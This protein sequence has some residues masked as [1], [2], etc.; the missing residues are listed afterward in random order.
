M[1]A[2]CYNPKYLR[3]RAEELRS[4]AETFSSDAKVKLLK[5]ADDYDELAV[6]AEER[7]KHG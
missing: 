2:N 7:S 3:D 5:C 1:T 4:V 6:R